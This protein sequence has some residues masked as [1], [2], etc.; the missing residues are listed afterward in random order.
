MKNIIVN[1]NVLMSFNIFSQELVLDILKQG[2]DMDENPSHVIK[3]IDQVNI[4]L[5][6]HNILRLTRRLE[7]LKDKD[8]KT[9]E[10]GDHILDFKNNIDIDML[11]KTLEHY[12][13]FSKYRKLTGLE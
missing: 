2:Q 1:E 4:P 9:F 8:E 10:L 12:R 11:C 3:P 7:E 13:R 5:E 6:G